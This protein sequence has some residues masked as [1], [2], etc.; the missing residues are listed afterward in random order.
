M[1]QQTGLGVRLLQTPQPEVAGAP[2]VV[3]LVQLPDL[4][5][6]Q[7]TTL[8]AVGGVQV[9]V[10]GD[11]EVR[12]ELPVT[13]EDGE[14]QT[15]LRLLLAGGTPLPVLRLLVEEVGATPRRQELAGQVPVILAIMVG[16]VACMIIFRY[17]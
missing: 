16:D 7:R 6:H 5:Q 10:A 1:H 12:R 14:A 13:A 9:V 3:P 8:G 4:G 11:G 17:L 15:L 2:H